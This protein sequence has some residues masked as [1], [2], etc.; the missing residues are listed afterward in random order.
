MSSSGKH[1][2]D[3]KFD[4]E[5]LAFTPEEMAA[6]PASTNER[7]DFQWPLPPSYPSHESYEMRTHAPQAPLPTATLAQAG[8]KPR[9][10]PFDFSFFKP[11]KDASRKYFIALIIFLTIII[12]TLVTVFSTLLAHA[13]K[14][15]PVPQN[16]TITTTLSTTLI[17]TQIEMQPI[18]A[19]QNYTTTQTATTTSTSVLPNPTSVSKCWDLL[20]NICANTTSVP[21]DTSTG[22]F[23]DCVPVFAFFYCGII[24]QFEKERLF[25]IPADDSPICGGMKEFCNGIA[26]GVTGSATKVVEGGPGVSIQVIT[27]TVLSA[28]KSTRTKSIAMTKI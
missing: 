3:R 11:K 6:G 17:S 10:P 5:D 19:T 2:E 8:P 26:V 27:S 20:S 1:Q 21:A 9:E 14:N 23:G 15:E 28:V 24:Q 12:V 4:E 22:E 18:T 25:I 7:P 16:I 13:R